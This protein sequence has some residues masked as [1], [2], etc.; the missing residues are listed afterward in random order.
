MDPSICIYGKSVQSGVET[1]NRANSVTRKKAAFDILNAAILI[2]K[3]EAE[4]FVS[5]KQ[6]AWDRNMCSQNVEGI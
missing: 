4:R 5:Y 3:L 2:L 6:Q 1:M